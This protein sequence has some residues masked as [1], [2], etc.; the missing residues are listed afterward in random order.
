M[1]L[2]VSIDRPSDL[3]LVTNVIHDCWFTTDGIVFH[4]TESALEIRFTRESS[5]TSAAGKPLSGTREKKRQVPCSLWIYHIEDFDINDSQ[6]VGR[7]DFNKLVY[8]RQSREIVILTGVPIEIR[9]RV[10]QFL[11]TVQEHASTA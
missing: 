7:Y 5:S 6:R 4:P 1:A 9:A 2:T 3:S 10:K 8:D 11:V